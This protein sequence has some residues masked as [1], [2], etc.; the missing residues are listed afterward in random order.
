M[1]NIDM[2]VNQLVCGA[3]RHQLQLQECCS[4]LHASVSEEAKYA[5]QH[6]CTV[7]TGV[8]LL[9]EHPGVRNMGAH[10]HNMYPSVM[11]G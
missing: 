2:H 1:H 9:Q 8:L 4:L 10:I 6:E 7:E 11:S 5:F 3:A